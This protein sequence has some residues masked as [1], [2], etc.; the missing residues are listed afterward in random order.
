MT[1]GSV[2]LSRATTP[3]PSCFS[4]AVEETVYYEEAKIKSGAR[5]LFLLSQSAS[6][7]LKK[8]T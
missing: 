8:F 6:I 1:R 7:I 5:Y 3:H 2:S 4:F